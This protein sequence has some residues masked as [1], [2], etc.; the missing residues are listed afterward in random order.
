[1]QNNEEQKSSNVMSYG[2]A[3][4]TTS[5]FQ[6]L[7]NHLET[8]T[9]CG[10]MLSTPTDMGHEYTESEFLREKFKLVLLDKKEDIFVGL[11]YLLTILHIIF[12]VIDCMKN[13]YNVSMR[14]AHVNYVLW[15]VFLLAPFL[16]WFYSTQLEYYNFTNRKLRTFSLCIVNG[17]FFLLDF[18]LYFSIQ[19]IVPLVLK[20]PLSPFITE[21]MVVNLCRL[22]LVISTILPP[23]L[24]GC[25][26]YKL[27]GDDS[28]K[29]TILGFRLNHYIDRR[30]N[31]AY[32]YDMNVVKELD[33]GKPHTI[34]QQDRTLHTIIDGTTGTGKTSSIISVA[35]ADDFDQRLINE[36]YQRKEILKLLKKDKVCLN[37]PMDD[38][39]FSM[40]AFSPT[41]DGK[42]EFDAILKTATSAGVTVLAPNAAL[43]DEVY[44]LAQARA[45][46]VNRVDPTIL[47]DGSHK[48]GFVG[49]NPLYISPTLSPLFRNLE[50]TKKARVCADVLQALYEMNGK[51]DPY[52]TSLNR[53]VTTCLIVL[54]LLTYDSLHKRNPNDERFSNKYPT[55]QIL[56][57]ILYDFNKSKVYVKEF[58]YLTSTYS[59]EE[60]GY[61]KRDYQF[62]IDLVNKDL[63]GEGREKMFDQARG[64]RTLI[65]EFLS[66]PLYRQVLCCQES[67][68]MD[69]ML[70]ENQITVVNYALELGRSDAVAFGLFFALSF[71][72]AVL[73]RPLKGRTPHYYYIDEFPVLL[74]PSME[75]CFTL[76][77]QYNV[78]MCVAIQ[79]LDQMNRSEFTKYLRGIVQGNCATQFVFG[80]ISTTEMDLYERLGGTKKE[81][82]EQRSVSETSLSMENT[83][84]S[85]SVRSSMQ[86]VNVLDGSKMRTLQFQEVTV[87]TVNEGSPLPP[88]YGKVSFLKKY[89]RLKRKRISYNWSE[90]F[91][92]HTKEAVGDANSVT[93]SSLSETKTRISVQSSIGE[94]KPVN[95]L[96]FTTGRTSVHILTEAAKNAESVTAD[97]PPEDT[98]EDAFDA[99]SGVPAVTSDSQT[100]DFSDEEDTDSAVNYFYLFNESE[101]M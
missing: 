37:H 95:V 54:I 80:R 74:H 15:A 44:D 35:V 101:D 43:A 55:L 67:I 19:L 87:F 83:S 13:I 65:D 38:L 2:G 59:P 31:A 93:F 97:V 76:F 27:L 98:A 58:N 72:N 10:K 25:S 85:F 26:I 91:P 73:R 62:V 94:D 56:Q 96:P 14:D 100:S 63:L 81:A 49:F 60:L 88:F 12:V 86:D 84:M 68:D 34:K 18:M 17:C 57:D 90:Y 71:N 29:E 28:V 32:S 11:I 3:R 70:S 53:N 39:D 24:T 22:L 79:T 5:L 66:N 47:E 48:E 1:M 99:S 89:K 40:N 92:E 51:G 7:E 21:S 8:L 30:E 82:V 69:A 16:A 61:K 4:D 9:D 6:N 33:T 41:E 46:K 50:V 64:L 20:I 77:R 23:V 75:E 36:E 45:L 78:A 52:F 42:A